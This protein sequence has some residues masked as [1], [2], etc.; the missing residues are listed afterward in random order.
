[1]LAGAIG[2]VGL[3]SFLQAM[4]QSVRSCTFDR[5]VSPSDDYLEFCHS[6]RE[7]IVDAGHWDSLSFNRCRIVIHL[8]NNHFWSAMIESLRSKL[9][10]CGTD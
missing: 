1:M 5:F 7:N 8:K 3:L 10:F 9:A 2:M 6:Q 4:S